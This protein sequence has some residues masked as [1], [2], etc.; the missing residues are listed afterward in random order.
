MSHSVTSQDFNFASF[1]QD[2]EDEKKIVKRK[3]VEVKPM[4]EEE[5]IIQM[6]LLGHQFYMYKDSET[7]KPA[8]VY[9]RKDEHY[10]I[11]ESE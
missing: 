7:N 9:K 4:D 11:I 3:K 8:V 10:G 6:E 1:E 2:D 5:A